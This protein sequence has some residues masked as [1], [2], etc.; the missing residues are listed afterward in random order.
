MPDNNATTRETPSGQA[1]GTALFILRPPARLFFSDTARRSLKVKYV[2]HV[3]ESSA[4]K[5]PA[6]SAPRT[7]AG[8]A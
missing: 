4:N 7:A 1:P 3:Y 6:E 8:N 2:R 5:S